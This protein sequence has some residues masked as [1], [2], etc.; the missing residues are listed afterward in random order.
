MT[1]LSDRFRKVAADFT[2]RVEAV[3]DGAWDNNAPCD[4]WVARDIVRHLVEWMP[5]FFLSGWDIDQPPIPSVDEDPQAA[6]EALRDAIQGALDDPDIASHARDTPMGHVTFEEAFAMAGLTD[7]LV[8]TWDLARATG[9]DERLDADE[10]HQLA[11]DIATIDDTPMRES[12]H[13]GPRVTVADD[14]DEQ[15]KILAFMGRHP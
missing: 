1:E 11:H 6:W 4:G 15:S 9:L 2:R 5:A 3:P 13:Y 8:H 14:A 7:V 12:G 10:V